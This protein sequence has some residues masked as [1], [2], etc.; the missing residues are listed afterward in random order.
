M[1]ILDRW[2]EPAIAKLPAGPRGL[3]VLERLLAWPCPLQIYGRKADLGDSFQP[4]TL[5]QVVEDML[6]GSRHV[7][8]TDQ[9]ERTA[10]GEV[11]RSVLLASLASTSHPETIHEG[12]RHYNAISFPFSAN[13]SLKAG[14]TV[15][16]YIS[17]NA[18][19]EK[20]GRHPGWA[21]TL[22]TPGS[23][24]DTHMDYHGPSQ[25][26]V[27]STHAEKLWLIWPPTDDN[28]SWWSSHHTRLAPEDATLEAMAHLEELQVFHCKAG[29]AFVIPPYT[30]HAVLTM[31]VSAHSG[32]SF[33][34]YDYLDETMR[35]LRW[36][37]EWAADFHR[38]GS[39]SK[40]ALKE[41]G[42]LRDTAIPALTSL[43][44][45]DHPRRKELEGFMVDIKG[46]VSE[47]N[48]Y[49]SSR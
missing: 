37:V 32:V 40:E 27:N 2:K 21:S 26:M 9:A 29:E 39:T 41:L 43:S 34:S 12:L 5:A 10:A 4:H 42:S 13:G 36:E 38:H 49:L 35:G 19:V 22:C 48:R 46:R 16:Q 47:V 33:W 6:A 28:L 20:R 15:P 31:Q 45:K 8:V 18:H 44:K 24:T 14:L 23:M 30:F 3:R 7:Q 11:D 17:Q 1:P 25:L